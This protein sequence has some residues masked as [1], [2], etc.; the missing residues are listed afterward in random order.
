MLWSDSHWVEVIAQELKAGDL[1]RVCDNERIPAD[2]L[3]VRSSSALSTCKLSTSTLDGETNLKTKFVVQLGQQWV[4]AP[5]NGSLVVNPPEH[6]IYNF[7]GYMQTENGHEAL[8]VKNLLWKG[9]QLKNT[10]F[11]E[12][13]VVYPGPLSKLMMNQ[14][15]APMKKSEVDRG[16]CDC[17]T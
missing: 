12:G 8:S 2:L 11:V 4:Q 16:F 17:G 10:E 15:T 9:T 3:L 7:S 6:N 14:V 13:I 1:V 5:T